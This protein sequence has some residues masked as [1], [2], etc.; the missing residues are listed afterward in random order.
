MLVVILI[1]LMDGTEGF[2]KITAV[3]MLAGLVDVVKHNKDT[4]IAVEGKS[5]GGD[6]IHLEMELFHILLER[7]ALIELVVECSDFKPEHLFLGGALCGGGNG[8]K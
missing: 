5:V 1:L 8:F 7:L 4:V 6:F 3:V 2:T